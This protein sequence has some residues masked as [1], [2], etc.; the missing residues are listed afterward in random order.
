MGRRRPGKR[1]IKDWLDDIGL[2]AEAV[3]GHFMDLTDPSK[4]VLPSKLNPHVQNR[5]QMLLREAVAVK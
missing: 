1:S 3:S 2:L 5:S 4:A